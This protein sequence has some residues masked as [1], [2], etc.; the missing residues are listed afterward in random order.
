ML[1]WKSSPLAPDAWVP[2]PTASEILKLLCFLST[3]SI[4]RESL[5]PDT[6]KGRLE[7]HMQFNNLP[8]FH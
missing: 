6:S 7:F 4:D 8:M 5:F 1:M 3:L 2:A